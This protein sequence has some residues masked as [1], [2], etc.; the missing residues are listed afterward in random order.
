M[1]R[2]AGAVAKQPEPHENAES[3]AGS[4]ASVSDLLGLRASAARRA[5]EA[6]ALEAAI[7]R[8]LPWSAAGRLMKAAAL[9][10]DEAARVWL[11]PRRTL[12]R[13]E[14]RHERF[15]PAESDRMA[16]FARILAHAI[17][18]L[19]DAGA[20]AKWL[21]RENRALGGRTPISLLSTDVGT[22]EV[23]DVLIRIE[24]GGYS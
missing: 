24:Y 1:A 23:E 16:R 11:I 14:A 4:P 10:K 7:E 9:D 17:H 15:R 21:H 22:R 8:G 13:R 20:A 19:E 18:V 12:D 2:D 3:H 6:R 5:N